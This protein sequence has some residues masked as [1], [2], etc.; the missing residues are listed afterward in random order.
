MK[1]IVIGLGKF[2]AQLAERLTSLGHEVLGID[3]DSYI[4]EKYKRNI[5]STLCVDVREEVAMQSLPLKGCDAVFITLGEHFDTSIHTA[6]LMKQFGVKRIIVRTISKLH[7]T[8][9]ETIGIEEIVSP[10]KEFAEVLAAR[11]ELSSQANVHM[12][13]DLHGVLEVKV[14][15][16]M[17]G[18]TLQ[19]VNFEEKYH[20]RLIGIK[21]PLEEKN[22]LGF[23][24]SKPQ[25]VEKLSPITLLRKEDHLLL[26]GRTDLFKNLNSL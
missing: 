12:I 26:F 3:S 1:Y 8:V 18:Q 24:V 2:G 5:T 21:R 23:T 17:V 15:P 22:L 4:V 20:L 19:E 10:E 7:R 25:I 14:P 6:A 9:L 16:F 13:T 11:V